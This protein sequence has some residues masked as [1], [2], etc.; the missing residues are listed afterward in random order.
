MSEKKFRTHY[1]N[2]KVSHDAPPEV[3]KAAYKTLIQKHH[4]DRNQNDQESHRILSI[5]NKSYEILSD[6][7]KR[8]EHDKWILEK[9]KESFG[10]KGYSV[11]SKVS[12]YKHDSSSPED[13]SSGTSQSSVNETSTVFFNVYLKKYNVT[14]FDL[15]RAIW[16]GEIKE[17]KLGGN[18]FVEDKPISASKAKGGGFKS[19]ALTFIVLLVIVFFVYFS[20][21]QP[22]Q[23]VSRN[24]AT[25]E[26]SLGQQ[27]LPYSSVISV[28]T[29]KPLVAPF[30]VF[31]SSSD[32]FLV[33]LKDV[34]TGQ[35]VITLF[36]RAGEQV[37]TKVP[38]GQYTQVYASGRFW[39]GRDL[40]FG[41]RTKFAKSLKTFDFYKMPDG[42]LMGKVVR[43][44]P[45]VN[46]NLRSTDINRSE[47]R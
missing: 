25:P 10:K 2:L 31:A 43:M 9:K 46:G 3:I 34:N 26:K 11:R 33:K 7:T 38:L 39:Y 36:V 22:N 1:D 19:F 44:Q 14:E 24:Y 5:V 21:N 28:Y 40:M 23:P 29:D 45:N 6:P 30:T 13:F 15:N 41:N 20:N 4:P 37:E 16:N 18:K 12:T 35:D 42:T 32:N 8:Q 17:I 47:F 27:P